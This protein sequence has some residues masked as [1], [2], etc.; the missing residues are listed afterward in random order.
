MFRTLASFFRLT[1]AGLTLARH[2]AIFPAEYQA[3][4]PAPVRGLGAFLRL[5]ARRD[6]EGS[7]GERLARA[8]EKLGPS[9]VKFGQVLATRADIVGQDFAR[10]LARL[11]D[12]MPAFDQKKAEA[13]VAAELGKPLSELF[14][15]FHAP[16]AAASVA[17]VHR[18]V[19]TDG[20]E[21]AVKVLRPGIEDR[22]AK[23]I[24]AMQLGAAI[25]E[26]LSPASRR[27][28]PRKFVD[29][30]ARATELETDLRLEAASASELAEASARAENY[31][32][33]E[34]D[35]P[36]SARRVLTTAWVDGIPLT[37]P[38]ALD[39]AG[40]DRENLAITLT[41]SFLVCAMDRGVFHADMHAGNLFA[42]RN[43]G[44]WAVDFG[45]MGR[46]GPGERRFLAQILHGFLTRD[47]VAAAEAHFR[48]GYV[49]A[50][51][52]VAD[53]A[54]ALRAVGEPIFGKSA[55]QVP[56]SRVLL[57]LFE[58]TDL[59]DMRL[60]PE[61]VLLQKTMVQSEGVSRALN[62][63]HDMWA[64]AAPV[65]ENWMRRE[66]G[67]EGIARDAVDDLKA[68]HASVRKLPSAIDD[69]AAAGAK[70]RSGEIRLDDDT[71]DRFAARGRKGAWVRFASYLAVAG[72]AGALAA[73]AVAS[74][75]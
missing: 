37:D 18:A 41:Q 71:L 57:Q 69:W 38:D 66:L 52:S 72:A 8:L 64:A 12:R 35:W 22:L 39:A 56:M 34:V 4:F 3:K 54:A 9:Y 17:Q 49:P 14:S 48:A 74:S 11:Q 21:V 59:F 60:R 42:D 28:E 32:I 67:P 1:R 2:D 44:L 20:R 31:F 7:P 23:D 62:P 19:T 61:L 73:W 25:V 75:L 15:E 68:L 43:G 47:Y 46:I 70:I 29:T 65:V 36:R 51:H 10:G 13:A 27:F 40:I 55:D 53:F 16:L 63:R 30:V 26:N 50:R 5:F 6:R 24:R 58:I 45:I 33:P